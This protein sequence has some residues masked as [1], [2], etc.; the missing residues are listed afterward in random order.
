MRCNMS[1]SFCFNAGL[2]VIDDMEVEE[3]R[4]MASVLS[5]RGITS[6]DV[7]GGEP[8]LHK[9]IE[10]LIGIALEAALKVTMSTN[11]TQIRVMQRLMETFGKGCG[12]GISV[13][14][15]DITENLESFIISYKPPVKSLFREGEELPSMIQTMVSKGVDEY[16]LIYPDISPDTREY[17][18]PFQRFHER[19]SE[20]RRNIPEICPVYCSGFLPDAEMYP[21]LLC[22]RC[23]AGVTKLGIMPDGSVYPCN[24]FFGMRE[25]YLGNI[26]SNGFDDI[27]SSAKLDF[28]R[29]FEKNNCP[30]RSCIL[31]A[32]CH[33]GCPAQ[34][35]RWYGRIDAPDPRCCL[36]SS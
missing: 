13:N 9:K 15:E 32:Q 36:T 5:R 3:F 23:A 35:L 1:C 11:G 4:E 20:L 14:G 34:S 27:W 19:I 18:V 22:S 2:G 7:L 26:L 16:Y 12:L 17:A 10:E 8:T 28:F 25:F 21:E 31:H 33:G 30:E 24:L 6:V 29:R